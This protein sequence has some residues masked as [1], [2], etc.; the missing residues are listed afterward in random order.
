MHKFSQNPSIHSFWRQGADKPF[1]NNLSPPVTLKMGSRSPKS[2]QFFF[3][4]QKY[5]CISLVKIHPF[6]QETGADKPFS[7]NL[8]LSMT[9]K[10][11]SRSLKSSLCLN[12]IDVHIWSKSIHS[13]RRLGADKP[14]SNN[15]SLSMTLKLGSRSLKSNQFFSMS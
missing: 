4:S 9:L 7:N 6:L 13:F 1:S 8:S 10:M 3:L 14:F 12:N 15:L 5:R 2:L 11:G